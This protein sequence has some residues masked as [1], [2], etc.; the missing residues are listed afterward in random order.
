MKQKMD[1]SMYEFQIVIHSFKTW[2]KLT[3]YNEN[4]MNISCKEIIYWKKQRHMNIFLERQSS[5][6]KFINSTEIGD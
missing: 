5:I 4:E 1:H 3:N 6:Y 2:K